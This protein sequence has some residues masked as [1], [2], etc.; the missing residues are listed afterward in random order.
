MSDMN[1]FIMGSGFGVLMSIIIMSW[2]MGAVVNA[3]TTMNKHTQKNT[4]EDE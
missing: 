2:F 1:M 3:A 4:T